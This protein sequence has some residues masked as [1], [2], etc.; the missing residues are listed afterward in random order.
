MSK[1]NMNL[2]DVRKLLALKRLEVPGENYFSGV[3]NEFHRRQE[4]AAKRSWF[5]RLRT[6]F[7][8]W[9]EALTPRLAMQYSLPVLAAVGL[10]ALT[11]SGL[12][13]GSTTGGSPMLALEVAPDHL[14]QGFAFSEG[15]ETDAQVPGMEI[16]LDTTMPHY[17]LADSATGY[18]ANLAF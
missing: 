16:E 7:A 17:V 3:V 9:R 4:E 14:E 5:A 1:Q 15:I 18:D 8:D 11:V 6:A 12:P 10:V 2:D 13:E